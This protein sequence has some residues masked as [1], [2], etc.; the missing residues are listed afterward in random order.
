MKLDVTRMQLDES[1]NSNFTITA[2]AGT[3]IEDVMRPEFFANV[4]YKF[5]PYDHIRARVD[6]GEW[7]AEF[8][9][10]SCGRVWAKV[11]PIFEINLVSKDI[12]VTQ[13]DASDDFEVMFRG[14]HL[15]WCIIR[16]ADRESIKD[17]IENKAEATA[18]L[19]AHARA[20]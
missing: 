4:A 11:I 8:L 15:K 12:E 17:G 18:W 5:H 7:Y 16:K 3:T 9:V 6:T 20:L 19:S 2:E 14:P 13:A 10:L 1:A